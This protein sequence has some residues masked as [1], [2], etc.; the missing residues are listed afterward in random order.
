[1]SALCALTIL[2]HTFS[3]QAQT[4]QLVFSESLAASSE[5]G[6][7]FKFVY[8]GS[9][10]T[11]TL[12]Q[13]LL[14]LR[15]TA[16]HGAVIS[17]ITD[18][19]GSTYTLG[20][21]ADSGAGGWITSLYY[22]AGVNAGIT[23]ITITYTAPVA[24]WHGAVAEYSGVATTA[25][26]D[27]SCSNHT[28]TVAC[29][30]AITTTGNNDLVIAT[31]IASGGTA[32]YRN[33]LST[34][35]PG[36]SFFLDAADTQSSDADEE[37][38]QTPPGSVTPSFTVTG[39]SQTFNIVGM[40][41][42]SAMAGTQPSG[43][44]IRHIQHV[45]ISTSANS[46]N[47]YFVSS[48]NLLVADTEVGVIGSTYDITGCTP[49][50][51][52]TKRTIGSYWPQFFY[53]PASGTFSTNLHCNFTNT[54]GGNNAHLVIYD[55]VG[56]AASPEDATSTAGEGTTPV[57]FNITP[58]KGPG[59]IFSCAFDGTGPVTGIEAGGLFD[60]TQYTGETDAG[61]LN[62]GDAWQHYF[63]KSPGLINGSYTMAIS[64][65]YMETSA[66]AFD[67]AAG[68]TSP[69]PPTNLQV[70]VH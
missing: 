2:S 62:D 58:T 63:Y 30:T 53:L 8:G 40:A 70:T 37:F 22:A 10:G 60:N 24:Q 21:S 43:M 52:W 12:A 33:T 64:S 31:M 49:T 34:I 6:N 29:S 65:S 42:K 51:N 46:Q 67:S 32:L 19:Q 54:G 59:I 68:G 36:G 18:N 1:L 15:I 44:F 50:N 39:N 17:S 45:Q 35:V 57:K 11:G 20:A 5:P 3:A 56:A 69:T 25:P 27:G 13:N 55:I 28:T 9:M 38:I 14:T 26:A 16:P 41:F 66:I 4:P 61:Q 7:G 47:V 48:G 23:L